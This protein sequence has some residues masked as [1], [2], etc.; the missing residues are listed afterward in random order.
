[1]SHFPL[2]SVIMS[3]YNGEKY[4]A[5][6]IG[7]VLDQSY[8][9]WE[10]LAVNDGSTDSSEKIL[11]SF[12]DDRIKYFY[13]P[14][15]GVSSGRN[16]GLKEMNGDFFCFLDADDQLTKDSL[17]SRIQKFIHEQNLDFVDGKVIKMNSDMTEQVS[18]WGPSFQ[19]NPFED[20]VQLTGNSFLGP[21]WMIR[22]KNGFSYQFRQGLTHCEDLLFFMDLSVS[23]GNY[24]HVNEVI[25]LY[26]IHKNSAMNNLDGLTAGYH[27]VYNWLKEKAEVN[28][29]HQFKQ[30]ANRIIF[31]SYLR[32]FQP[33]K[34]VFKRIR[35]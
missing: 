17:K 21:T 1:M 13:K 4:L 12:K 25:L 5:E 23:S 31:R 27:Y 9:N 20:L 16:L 22:K 35:K 10:L 15:G 7:S 29:Y 6:A 8:Q 14:N 33:M 2:V 32:S 26:R 24:D 19:G 28:L 3:F 18:I 34:A 30:R 11:L